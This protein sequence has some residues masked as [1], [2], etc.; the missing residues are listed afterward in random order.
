MLFLLMVINWADKAILGLTAAQ[1]IPEFGLTTSQFGFLGSAFY[2][3]YGITCL[4][5]GWVMTKVSGRAILIVLAILWSVTQLP[6]LLVASFGSLLFSRIGLGAAEGPF[7]P[8]ANN[9]AYSW[10]PNEKRGLPQGILSAGASV[11][12]IA[13]APLLTLIIVAYGW[14]WGFITLIAIG[15]V[16]T[17]AWLLV[18]QEGPHATMTSAAAVPEEEVAGHSVTQAENDVPLSKVLF[19]RT[20]VATV[21]A[22][23]PHGTLLAI[24]L[25]F[26]PTYFMSAFGMSETAAGSLLG[27]P[28]ISSLIVLVGSGWLSDRLLRRGK[29]SKVARVYV[30]AGALVLGG[31]ILACLPLAT[32]S[33]AAIVMLVLGY[34]IA[35]AIYPIGPPLIAEVSPRK[36]RAKTQAILY[37]FIACAGIIGPWL[38]GIIAETG[39]TP[40]E[41]FGRAFQVFGIA[42]IVAGV[43][44]A[45][46]ANPAGDREKLGAEAT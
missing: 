35:T 26:L 40:A 5:I 24:V 41:G 31:I 16:W 25:T 23:F 19:C 9:V 8:V 29:P 37:A 39:A 14:R 12:K 43:V 15:I 11:A 32:S 22:M 1:I 18:G 46:L 45:L 28:S 17:V 3:L 20:N 4:A 42:V 21:I 7:N 36:H 6:V 13:V 34:G 33:T 10:F 44:F 38:T 30:G 2:F 27:L